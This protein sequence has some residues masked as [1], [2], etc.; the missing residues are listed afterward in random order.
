M[1][2]CAARAS[3]LGALLLTA[4]ALAQDAANS[5]G[6]VEGKS[7]TSPQQEQQT[8]E[9]LQSESGQAGRDEPG[10]HTVFQEGPPVFKNGRLDVPGVPQDGPTVPAKF[11]ERN[12]TLDK[13]PIVILSDKQKKALL[14]GAGGRLAQVNAT[15]SQEIPPDVELNDLPEQVASLPALRGLKYIRLT[16]HVILVDAASRRVVGTIT[17]PSSRPRE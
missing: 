14:T 3:F 4:S 13:L 11:S 16:D 17:D 7:L 10:S 1:R 8:D 15:F 9:S 6:K 5:S 2:A 12:A